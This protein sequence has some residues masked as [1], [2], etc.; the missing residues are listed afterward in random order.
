MRVFSTKEVFCEKGEDTIHQHAYLTLSSQTVA[1]WSTAWHKAAR[2][3][4]ASEA[5]G[6]G[7]SVKYSGRATRYPSCS[8][9]ST[10]LNLCL[11]SIS[12]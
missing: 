4:C 2:L 5:V 8:Q 7:L 12:R 9:H 11:P 10:T 6:G 1:N 3:A